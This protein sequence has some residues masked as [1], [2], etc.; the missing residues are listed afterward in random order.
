[1][2]QSEAAREEIAEVVAGRGDRKL[3]SIRSPGAKSWGFFFAPA[4]LS[5]RCGDGTSYN[6]VELPEAGESS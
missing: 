2:S 6:D 3:L 1:M 4:A 5:F